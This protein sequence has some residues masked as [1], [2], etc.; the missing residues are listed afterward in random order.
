MARQFSYTALFEPA[1]EG[2][3]VVTFPAIPGLATQG[4]TLDEASAMAEDCLR[5]YLGSLAID[6]EP[7]PDDPVAPAPHGKRAIVT[8]EASEY[9]QRKE[10]GRRVLRL[11]EV[12]DS[13]I[14]AMPRAELPPEHRRS[15]AEI[16]D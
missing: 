1:E 7:A 5:A 14:E 6:G 11:A 4:E 10:P 15:L 16:P 3:F 9:A 8:V 2:G 12:P 13:D